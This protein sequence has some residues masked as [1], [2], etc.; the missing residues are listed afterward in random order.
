MGST[1]KI[2]RGDTRTLNVGIRNK[3]ELIDTTGYTIYFTVRS[4]IP[5]TT[6]TNDTGAVISQSEAGS[7]S[8]VS[9]FT[10]SST[11][12]TQNPAVYSYDIQYKKPDGSIHSSGTGKFIIEADITRGAA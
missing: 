3:G 8:G 7:T 2:K 9:V 12:T 1:I 10:L 4:T 5:P 11:D 6:E